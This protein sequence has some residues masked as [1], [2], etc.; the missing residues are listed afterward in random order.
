VTPFSVTSITVNL[1]RRTSVTELH[2]NQVTEST[3][4]H[5]G[6]PIQ[7]DLYKQCHVNFHHRFYVIDIS[8]FSE[9]CFSKHI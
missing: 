8:I 7:Y 2:T 3:I 1:L 6:K 4:M 5:Y 9:L